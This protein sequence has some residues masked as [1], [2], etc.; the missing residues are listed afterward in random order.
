M[1]DKEIKELVRL[2][3]KQAIASVLADIEQ[4]YDQ[5]SYP[6]VKSGAESMARKQGWRKGVYD[7]VYILKQQLESIKVDE[8]NNHM[9]GELSNTDENIGFVEWQ[10]KEGES[11]LCGC[12]RAVKLT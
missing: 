1:Q 9:F 12:S 3:K 10:N 8:V 2:I 4:W 11:I 7:V 6:G 5:K